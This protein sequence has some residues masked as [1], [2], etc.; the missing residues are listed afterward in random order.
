MGEPPWKQNLRLACQILSAVAG[1][2]TLLAYLGFKPGDNCGTQVPPTIAPERPVWLLIGSILLFLFSLGLVLYDRRRFKRTISTLEVKGR[3]DR[4]EI[5]RLKALPA[6]ESTV[7]RGAP[8]V[9][10]SYIRSDSLSERSKLVFHNDREETRATVRSIGP[11]VSR[12]LYEGQ[13][14]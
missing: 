1:F 2:C 9:R 12:E 8:D 3:E 7:L 10:V 13:Y 11:V 14:Q 4:A 6:A 5:E